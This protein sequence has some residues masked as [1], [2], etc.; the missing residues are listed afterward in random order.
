M[1]QISYFTLKYFLK[2]K[3]KDILLQNP[4]VIAIPKKINSNIINNN[5]QLKSKCP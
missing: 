1:L 3:N 5:I 2:H 4:N